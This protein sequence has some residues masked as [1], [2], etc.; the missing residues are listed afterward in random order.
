MHPALPYLDVFK[1][2]KRE[3][4]GQFLVEVQKAQKSPI[5]DPILAGV[6]S[7]ADNSTFQQ[8][9]SPTSGLTYYDLELGAK[10]V[11]P[12]LTPLRNE[13]PRVSGKGGIQAAW[14]AVTGVNTTNL[15]AGV[16]PGNRGAIQAVST[17]N[18]TA[19]YK[20]LGLE[21]WVDFEAQYAGMGFDDIRAIGAKVGLEATMIQ[22]ELVILGG[23]TDL[24]LGLTP[25]PAVSNLAGTSGALL[26]N[27]TYSVICAAL[28]FDAYYRGSVTGGVN[29]S[30]TRQNADGS[31][32]TFGGGTAMVSAHGSVT[33]PNDS[34]DTHTIQATVTPVVGAVGYAWFWGPVGHEVLGAITTINS[35]V[36]AANAA[37]TQSA[38]SLGSNDN[39]TNDLEFDGFLYLAMTSGSNAY[40][41]SQ[42]TGVAGTGTPLTGD[43]AG[44]IV[45]IDLAL[46]N[47]WDNYR[48]SPDTIWVSSQEANNLSKKI[49]A[50]QTNAAQRF[51]FESEQSALGGGVMVRSYLNKFSMAAGKEL[52][53]RIHPNMPAG[54]VL[55]T[56]KT[57]P[58]PMSNISSVSQIRYRQDYYQIEWPLR[59][60]RYES[61]VYMDEVLQHYFPPSMAVIT[62]IGNG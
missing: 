26:Y 37:G 53:I 61:G 31:T 51:V 40:F 43:G 60:R 3:D 57:L 25:T 9:V 28:A 48:L 11:Y 30:V 32:D 2:M 59:S 7:K 18:Y 12:V 39:S 29:G 24:Q 58:Y 20:G 47:R 33:T 62:N 27:T 50:G 10:F 42:A 41:A 4:I 35:V 16:S 13:T 55:M 17:Q 44:G 8:S 34:V 22:E 52:D 36:I 49:L 56:S 38:A 19:S 15:Y 54:T 14:R 46:K 5:M 1:G 21:T 45:E 23:N 6:L